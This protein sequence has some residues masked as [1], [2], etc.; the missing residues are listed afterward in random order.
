M[1][2]WAYFQ[3]QHRLGLPL[4]WVAYEDW[5]ILGAAAQDTHA[6][7]DLL[8]AANDG[9]QLRRLC[10][11]VRAVFLQRLKLLVRC[12]GVHAGAAATHALQRIVQLALADACSRAPPI[13]RQGV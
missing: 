11:E 2:K 13:R 3:Q 5:I 7:A 6:A 10:G 1:N 4:T 12:I 8:I 9:V